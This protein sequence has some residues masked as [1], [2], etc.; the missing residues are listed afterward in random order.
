M[1]FKWTDMQYA[2]SDLFVSKFVFVKFLY[3]EVSLSIS[4]RYSS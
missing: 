4:S 2:E 3:V 1:F